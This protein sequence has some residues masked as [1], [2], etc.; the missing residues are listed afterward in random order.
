VVI[1]F[2][3]DPQGLASLRGLLQV[4]TKSPT[5]MLYVGPDQIMPITSVLSALVGVAL[6]FWSRIVLFVSRTWAALRRRP[7]APQADARE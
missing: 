1:P 3:H 5:I 7:R 6:M 4:F 2:G